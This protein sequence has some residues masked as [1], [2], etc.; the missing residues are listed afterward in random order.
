MALLFVVIVIVLC[1]LALFLL[2]TAMMSGYSF[3]I[4]CRNATSNSVN[5]MSLINSL[6]VW[7]YPYVLPRFSE[8][9]QNLVVCH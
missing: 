7:M 3:W 1:R 8:M 9:K 6:S 4:S 2:H 5:K